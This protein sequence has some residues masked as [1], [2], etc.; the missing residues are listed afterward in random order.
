MFRFAN[1][2]A[3]LL[4]ITPLIWI[5][6]RYTRPHTA[7]P[8]VTFSDTRLLTRLPQSW[9]VRLTYLPDALRI[10]AWVLLVLIIARPQSGQQ[11][12]IIRGQGIDIV[13][14][15]DISVSMSAQDITP[16]RLDAAKTQIE[17]FIVGRNFDRIGL[18]VFGADAYHYVPPTLDHD[19]LIN[20]LED[21]RLISEYGLDAAGTAIGTGLASAVNMLRDS[22]AESQIVV[23]LT[24]GSNNTGKI[25]PLDAARAAATLGI[26]VYTIGM[27]RAIPP[28]LE[29]ATNRGNFDEETLQT[30]AQVSDGL[31]FQ[32]S[33]NFGLQQT[34][35]QIDAL[36]RSDIEQ[37]IFTRWRDRAQPLLILTLLCLLAERLLRQTIFQAIP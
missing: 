5:T 6:I 30:I 8:A 12:E 33:D 13:I 2:L 11:R 17:R 10:L 7:L 32:V 9:R 15:L 36:E 23:L 21:V 37:Q 34:Y 16:T 29:T 27:G 28:T 1:P 26:R 35:D 18:V 14:A 24:D 3:L 19:L 20:R 22:N 31:Y 25:N 4:L